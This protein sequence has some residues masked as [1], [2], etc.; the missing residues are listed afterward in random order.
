MSNAP[1]PIDPV[2][3]GIAIQYRN[4]A[5]IADMVLPRITPELPRKEFKYNVWTKAE[6]FTVPNTAVGRRGKPQEIEFTATQVT[7][8]VLDYALDDPIPF[9]DIQNAPEG[10]DPEAFA[11]QSLAGLIALDR[12][13][14]VAGLVFAG[15]T[16]PSANK[17]ALS[18]TGAGGQWSASDSTPID[19]ILTGLDVPL[20]R[21][22][23]MVIGRQAFSKLSTHPQIAKAVLGNSGDSTIASA[24]QIANL[25]S[26]ERVLV[27]E[28][29]QNTAKRGQTAS[30]GRVWGKACALLYIDTLSAGDGRLPSFG[31]TFQYGPRLAGA[32]DDEDI[33]ARGGRRVRVLESVVEKI[34]ASDLGYFI[35]TVIA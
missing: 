23:T 18:G 15:G 14:R 22:N 19:D 10:H 26:L 1:F 16:Y 27:G 9:D 35:D 24:Q 20:I 7:G 2:L 33:G 11:V 31:G 34:T 21:P 29:Y 6:Q 25:F 4:K 32:M 8:A 5:L 3:T 30:Y 28:G 13:A 17:T 12:E